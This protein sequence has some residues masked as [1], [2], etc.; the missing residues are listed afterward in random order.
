LLIVD[1]PAGLSVHAGTGVAHGLIERA[2]AARPSGDYLEL[3]HRL[4][5]ET[6]GCLM[7]AK[8]PRR[9]RELHGLFRNGDIQKRYLTLVRGRWP[10]IN[11][12]TTRLNR[13][14]QEGL[15]KMVVD[16][17]GKPAKSRFTNAE[18]YQQSSLMAVELYSGRTHQIRVHAA[19]QGHPVAGD[20]RYGE[21]GFNREMR[22][23]GLRRMFLHANL[24]S[25]PDVNGEKIVVS[26][27]LPG[28]LRDVLSALQ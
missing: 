5:R 7:L 21:R 18:Q 11:D 17:D 22:R 19:D 10:G 23:T 14:G 16:E 3:V 13:T 25:F 27:P 4:D 8:E 28:E 9:L 26:S 2:R 6:S 20:V 1:K 15:A 12:V 24:L